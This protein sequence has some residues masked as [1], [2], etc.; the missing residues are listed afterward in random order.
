[1]DLDLSYPSIADLARRAK[2][3]LPSF[4]WEYLDSGTGDD[5]ARDRNR[6][7]LDE[8]LFRTGILQGPKDTDLAT[9]LL[10]DTW[11]LPVGVAPVGMSGLIWPEGEKIIAAAATRAGV[12][13]CLST[14]ASMMP[15]DVGP[16][17]GG[18]GW[19]QLY[20]PGD[21]EIRRD[22]LDRAWSAGFR[23]LVLTADVSVASRRER[24]RRAGIS[25]P[26]K[27][28]PKA[29][30]DAALH[31]AW[32]LATAS[33]GIPRLRTLEKYAEIQSSRPGTAHIGYL[34]RT[35]PDE[36]YVKA[37]REEWKGNLVV[38]GVLGAGAAKKLPDLGVDAIW[39]SNHG[40]RQ[41]DGAA[42]G[43]TALPAI[44]A[45]LPDTP[46]IYDGGI[47]S[48]T[49]ILR[50]IAL[51]ADFTFVGRAPHY[52]LAAFG[53][54]GVEH[55][56]EIFKASLEADLGQMALVR[57]IETRDRLVS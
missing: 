8:V 45:A 57:P 14:V 40:G 13:Y 18:R 26:M 10:G 36:N 33:H 37:L 30:I 31:P 56:F 1:M 53:A 15:E 35:V 29:V 2:R 7:A 20:P 42:P 38:K 19:Y 11:S 5:K 49:D 6:S 21:P 17:T 25:N 3:R 51:G 50:A 47:A 32:A 4:V 22:M 43:L 41:F 55:V 28:T 44:R 48:G 23:T 52:G 9:D 24:L 12:P 39:V 46:L 27:I 16:H 34:L 54:S